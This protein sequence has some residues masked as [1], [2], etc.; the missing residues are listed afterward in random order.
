MAQGDGNVRT[1]PAATRNASGALSGIRVIEAGIVMQV[2]LA[3]QMLGDLGA[4]VIKVERPGGDLVRH[5]DPDLAPTGG[6][7]TYFAALGRNKR[8]IGL[9]VKREGAREAFLRLVDG[10]DVLIHNFRPGVMEKLGL[11]YEDLAARNPRLVYAVG[12]G[13]G[14][15]GPMAG[16]PG[17]D[18]LAQS[19]SGF[20]MSGCADGD[21]PRLSNSPII[22][23]TT[24][25]TLTQG[26]LA[27]LLE[28]ERS[29]MGQRVT[30]SLLDVAFSAQ[31]TEVA[32][33][34]V[35]G[36][37]SNWID[38]AMVFR[39]TDGWVAVLMLFRDNPLR[40]LCEAFGRDDLSLGGDFDTKPKQIARS[41]EIRDLLQPEFTGRS[42][43]EVLRLLAGVDI[44][45][46]PVNLLEEA[47]ASA[48]IASNGTLWPIALPQAHGRSREVR[49]VGNPCR[50]SRTPPAVRH[51]P[52]PAGA[53]TDE[54]LGEIGY[55]ADAIARL[56]AD[57]AAF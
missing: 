10:A 32:S 3:A 4:D 12:Y 2:P 13:F 8:C 7:G 9:D 27:A 18:L 22:D 1:E 44:L 31:M 35:R 57:R 11:G 40:L 33:L 50:L 38:Q 39:A 43:A 54:I 25:A 46:A 30:T 5:L 15:G 21:P 37:R 49:L 24:A 14:E 51:E 26:I 19:Y 36:T 28:R 20:A 45:C 55:G 29:G 56:R 17:Q 34:A 42:I 41:G 16:M 23:Y 48:Q 47:M 52:A 6:V 53:H